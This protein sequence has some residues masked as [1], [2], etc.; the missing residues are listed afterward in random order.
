MA[1]INAIDY[2][3][4]RRAITEIEHTEISLNGVNSTMRQHTDALATAYTGGSGTKY[5]ILMQSWSEKFN[6]IIRQLDRIKGSLKD[7][8]NDN[9]KNEENNSPMINRIQNILQTS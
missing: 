6:D 1:N 7:N 5:N 4:M 8:L 3:A 9:M 2:D